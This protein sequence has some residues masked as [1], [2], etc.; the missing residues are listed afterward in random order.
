[1]DVH[2]AIRLRKSVRTYL[3]EQIPDRVLKRVLEAGRLAPSAR[4]LQPWRFI[5]VKNPSSRKAIARTGRFASFL[6]EAPA[7]I[8]GCG[9][10]ETSPKWFVVDVSIALQNMVMAAT[11]E[12]LG[13][14]WIGSFDG[15]KVKEI[16]RIPQGL[17]VVA[18]LAMGYPKEPVVGP[19]GE[20][21]AMNRKPLSEI[22]M[23]DEYGKPLE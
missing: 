5:V 2:D 10:R 1:M 15:E 8:V 18:L 11:A 23:L 4:N 22:A 13:T 7:V 6:E 16:L 9:D 14:C 12:G 19:S 17:E 21:S 20:R 3:P